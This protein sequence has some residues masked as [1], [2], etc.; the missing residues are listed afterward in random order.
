MN[1]EIMSKFEIEIVHYFESE[2][3]VAEIYYD[4]FQWAEISKENGETK[5]EFYSHPDKEHWE[6]PC[7]EAIKILERAKNIF[8]TRRNKRSSLQEEVVLDPKQINE[9]A[10]KVLEG[11]VNH[12]QKKMIQGRLKRF[13]NVVDIYAPDMGGARYRADGEFIGFL[14]P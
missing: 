14:E 5:I 10:Q 9:Q 1:Y 4:S 13:G 2:G 12:P 8:L 11:I 3:S 6:F 7:E